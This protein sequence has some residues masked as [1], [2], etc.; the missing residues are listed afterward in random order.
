MTLIVVPSV[1]TGGNDTPLW[2]ATRRPLFRHE[3]L[4]WLCGWHEAAAML[5][6][7]FVAHS[8]NETGAGRAEHNYNLGGIRAFSSQSFEAFVRSG[9]SWRS[10]RSLRD[11][12]RGYLSTML[13]NEARRS[14]CFA[15]LDHGDGARWYR[16]AILGTGYDNAESAVDGFS[17]LWQIELDSA[18]GL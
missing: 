10:Y 18:S 6:F 2:L 15:Y 5:S 13:G 3:L 17:R 7:V 16:E 11:G 4:P 12:V 8:R 14:A 9:L 1:Q